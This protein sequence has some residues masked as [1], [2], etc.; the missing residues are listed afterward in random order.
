MGTIHDELKQSAEHLRK[1]GDALADRV[2][3]TQATG[4]LRAAA[5]SAIR[6]A[7][8]ALDKAEQQLDEPKSGA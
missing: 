6:A 4:H 3:G 5:R 8:G 2:L 7:R 1:A